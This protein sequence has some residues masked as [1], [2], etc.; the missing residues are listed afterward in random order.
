MSDPIRRLCL[1]IFTSRALVAWLEERGEHAS[2]ERT[3]DFSCDVRERVE[4]D[5]DSR[6]R[7]EL[8]SLL[9]LP[10]LRYA[11]FRHV[12]AK[13]YFLIRFDCNPGTKVQCS[14]SRRAEEQHCARR[15][16]PLVDDSL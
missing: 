10:S 8:E 15:C 4:K 6:L 5:G 11:S 9:T 16:N 3:N 7:N 14:V 12:P 1:R 13:V 2:F